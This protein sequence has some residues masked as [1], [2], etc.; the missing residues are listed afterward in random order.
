MI[1]AWVGDSNSALEQLTFLGK[2]PGGPAYGE[3]KYDPAWDAVRGDPRFTAMLN[4]LQPRQ[5]ESR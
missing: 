5:K 3:L 1:Y 2:T 4:E